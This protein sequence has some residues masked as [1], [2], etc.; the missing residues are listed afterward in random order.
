VYDCIETDP[1]KHPSLEEAKEQEV[2]EWQDGKIP[3]LPTT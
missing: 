3:S 1:T 2:P